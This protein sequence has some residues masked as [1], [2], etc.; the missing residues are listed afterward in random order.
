MLFPV[1]AQLNMAAPRL[2]ELPPTPMMQRLVLESPWA[3]AGLLLVLG[4]ASFLLLNARRRARH[5]LLAGGVCVAL[6]SCVVLVA[7]LVTTKREELVRD[8]ESLFDALARAD[9]GRVERLL[10]PAATAGAPGALRKDLTRDE[11]LDLVR[12]ARD[13]RGEYRV[14]GDRIGVQD[15]RIR[16]VR[17][18]LASHTIGR[19]QI[20]VVITPTSG[21]ITPTWWELDWDRIDGR[22]RLRRI[23]LVWVAGVRSIGPR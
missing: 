5:G 17:A 10:G 11:L 23:D 22:W 7:T 13:A 3:I 15:Y 6:A 9:A 18:A 19:S 12:D 16:E 1:M 4:A 2:R 21:T 8:T 20:N 14:A